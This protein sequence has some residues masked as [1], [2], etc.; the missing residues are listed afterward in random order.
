MTK[1]LITFKYLC[2]KIQAFEY[3]DYIPDMTDEEAKEVAIS[4]L[5]WSIDNHLDAELLDY[6]LSSVRGE[7]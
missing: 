7:N 1:N 5:H 2:D 6:F 3:D 4:F